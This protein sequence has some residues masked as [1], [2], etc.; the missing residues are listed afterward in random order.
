[1]TR[2]PASWFWGI[3]R[4]RAMSIFRRA[5]LC[6]AVFAAV[7]AQFSPAPARAQ[8]VCV[9]DCGGT[10]TVGI[11]DLV[12]LV[13]IV[14]GNVDESVCQQGIPSGVKAD[15]S[16][17]I[18]AVNDALGSCPISLQ[19]VSFQH[20][21]NSGPQVP[22]PVT[23]DGTLNVSSTGVVTG[24]I[25]TTY[26]M[27]G[28]ATIVAG[29]GGTV[30][31]QVGGSL[32]DLMPDDPESFA[33]NGTPLS[34]ADALAAY[35]ADANSGAS[36]EQWSVPGQAMLAVVA[37][38]STPSWAADA[39]AVL[40]ALGN[41]AGTTASLLPAFAASAGDTS[42]VGVFCKL[43]AAGVTAGG[44]TFCVVGTVGCATNKVAKYFWAP[45][46]F[47]EVPCALVA[48]ICTPFGYEGVSLYT[49]LTNRWRSNPTPTTT[50]AATTTA[51][52]AATVTATAI[53]TATGTITA[54]GTATAAA[55]PSA[56]PTGYV[57]NP[58]LMFGGQCSATITS[59]PSSGYDGTTYSVTIF[60]SPG[61]EFVTSAVGIC[62]GTFPLSSFTAGVYN[63][64]FQAGCSGNVPCDIPFSVFG[65]DAGGNPICCNS[66]SVK[67]LGPA[68]DGTPCDNKTPCTG[69]TCGSNGLCC[70]DIPDCPQGTPCGFDICDFGLTCTD[71]TCQPDNSGP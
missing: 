57:C 13:N 65:L 53:P 60:F 10:G 64:Q 45:G 15:I 21:T 71:G 25:T 55:T 49:D 39:T 24:Q 35:V 14:L 66:N 16:T 44:I 5:A 29:S 54:T 23:L 63:W 68:S 18:Q 33:I 6:L 7:L 37:L 2:E 70:G 22:T 69:G 50:P 62:N 34:V 32:F 31:V 36:P 17:I 30:T 40:P 67:G 38:V 47:L 3:A 28:M 26:G 9:G 58:A 19:P 8:S 12:T 51:T 59:D 42:D 41:P 46:K 52:E 27:G 4:K 43:T 61:A 56:T 48:A 11:T 1:V 20:E